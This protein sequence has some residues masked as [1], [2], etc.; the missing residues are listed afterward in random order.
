MKMR[1]MGTRDECDLMVEVF[2]RNIP[3]QY[4]RSIS[5]FCPNRGYTTE[6]R[7]YIDLDLPVGGQEVL[8]DTMR[9]KEWSL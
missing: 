8:D 2:K 9:L 7:V 3:R 5:N 4:V 6:G 1:I